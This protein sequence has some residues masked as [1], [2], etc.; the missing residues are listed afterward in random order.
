LVH[1]PDRIV[2][3]AAVVGAGWVGVVSAAKLL[4]GSAY[5]AFA[6]VTLGLLCFVWLGLFAG[7]TGPL[8]VAAW[9]LLIANGVH[10]LS[11]TRPALRP[12]WYRALVS[13]PALW[14][15]AASIL[16][17]PWAV[18][19]L[20]GGPTL[21][22]W[23]PYAAA[24]FGVWQ[25][26]RN[27]R[28]EVPLLLD[29]SDAGELSRHR[30][31]SPE[32]DG[33]RIVQITDP[34]L[35]PFMSV[36]RLRGICDRAVA[37][38]PDLVLITGDL[39]TMESHGAVD[40][41][42]E[43]L[44]PL[45]A[46]PGRVFACYGN[47]DHEARATVDG[48]LRRIGATLLVDQMAVADTRLGPVEVVGADF[49]W[50]ERGQHLADLFERIGLRGDRPRLL[51]LHDP[52]AFKHVPDGAADLTLAGHTHGGHVGLL[53]LGSPWTSIGAMAGM[54]DHGLWSEGRNRLY[55]HRG[56]GHYGY[57]I[58]LG[59]PGEESVLRLLFAD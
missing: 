39:L 26:L 18:S 50:R 25:S 48:A 14:F 22:W 30:R 52:G 12:V 10:Y 5:A 43:A 36:A 49:V 54:P 40:A 15:S 31:G 3:T 58:R 9:T 6:G 16:A 37:D 2:L 23:L 56:T 1:G 20:L 19:A 47:H 55:V 59:V 32:G 24:V 34:H 35:G 4:R 57:P 28:E 17:L 42:A 21:G 44:S 27:P 41:L 7:A 11:L 46:L 13:V 29:R 8:A 33:L 45:A 51:M 53:S 38:D